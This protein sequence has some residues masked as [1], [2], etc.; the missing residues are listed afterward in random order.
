MGLLESDPDDAFSV[1]ADGT[2]RVQLNT[3]S[4]SDLANWRFADL[5][6]VDFSAVMDRLADVASLVAMMLPPPRR[7]RHLACVAWLP[8][9]VDV[10]R[11]VLGS[12]PAITAHDPGKRTSQ[13]CLR[14]EFFPTR[15][16]K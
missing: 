16:T 14:W 15:A 8:P 9:L 5:V 1:H 10:P 11:I 7:T 13:C 2:W 6:Q 4:L 12:G 3:V